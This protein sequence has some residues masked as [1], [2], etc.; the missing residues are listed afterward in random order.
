MWVDLAEG[1]SKLAPPAIQMVRVH[2]SI[3]ARR[4]G[5]QRRRRQPRQ[6]PQAS[7]DLLQRA[8]TAY[9]AG[10][11]L[12]TV[13]RQV[14]LGH[15]RLAR[16]LQE[17][18]VVLRNHSPSSSEIRL[19]RAMYGAR[20]LPGACGRQVRLHGRD[21]PQTIDHRRRP[22][23]RHAQPRST[24]AST[25]G[26]SL[27]SNLRRGIRD[28]LDNLTGQAERAALVAGPKY[29]HAYPPRPGREGGSAAHG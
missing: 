13:A 28:T 24:P 10:G 9:A 26:P 5:P 21:S 8:E 22:D 25:A 11:S 15:E 6:A 27:K 17:R 16:L 4:H 1:L 3:R 7:D 19:M 2:Q 29:P 20:G 14:G 18:G 23:A 12:K